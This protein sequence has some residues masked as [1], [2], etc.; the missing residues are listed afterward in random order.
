M[1]DAAGYPPADGRRSS[2]KNDPVSWLMI[3]PGW[4]LVSSDGVGV[5]RVG[6]VAGDDATDIFDDLAVTT[7]ALGEPRYV[8]AAHVG[9][10]RTTSST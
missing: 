2:S 5:G 4:K 8:L 9:R 6:E 10:S 7:S 3:E 1:L